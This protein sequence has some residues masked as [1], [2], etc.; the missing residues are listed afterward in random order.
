MIWVSLLLTLRVAYFG[1]NTGYYLRRSMSRARE[2]T[3]R[4]DPVSSSINSLTN[5]SPDPH[6][7]LV[8]YVPPTGYTGNDTLVYDFRASH[9][10][11]SVPVRDQG[12][13][14]GSWAIAAVDMFSMYH[15]SMYGDEAT[16]FSPQY[17]LSCFSDTGC[18]GEDARA[19]FLFLTEV[20]I[21][22]EECFP[23]NS[24]EHGVPP[25]CPNACVDGSTPS[26]NRISKA[27]IYGGNATRIAELLMQKGP[28]YAELFVYKDLLTYHGGIYNRT[29]TDYIGT[30]AVILVGFGVDTTRNVSY[31]IAQNSWGSSWGE[32]GFFRIL[33]GVNECGIE[34][35][36]VYIDT[37][38]NAPM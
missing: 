25:A 32:D 33:K 35:R 12:L 6:C 17:L 14:S 19:G 13:C 31:W 30:Q 38:H 2:P 11:C 5:T 1:I 26:F 28:L 3:S 29:S 37:E 27:H 21:T 15:C 24:S 23:F 7:E 9:P 22:S 36:V 16:L 4:V 34:N 10:A 18:F 8:H 20:G